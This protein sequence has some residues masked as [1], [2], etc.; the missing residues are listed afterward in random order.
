MIQSMTGYGKATAVLNHKHIDIE[1][2][3]LNSKNIDVN[4]RMPSEL[5]PFELGWRKSITQTLKRGKVDVQFNI[6]NSEQSKSISFNKPLVKSY[7]E[8]L[9][10]IIRVRD[11]MDNA[12]LLEIA[13][14]L[15]DAFQSEE[16]EMTKEDQTKLNNALK[17]ALQQVETFRHQEG[18][19]LME[20]FKN[21]LNEIEQHLKRIHEIDQNRVERVKT[22]LKSTLEELSVDYDKNR[23]EQELIYYIEKFD[24]SEEKTRLKSHIE[25]FENTLNLPE[26]NGKKLNFISQEMG[27]EINTIGSKANDAEIQNLVV[28]MKD[29]LEKI[30]EQM[31]NIL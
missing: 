18:Q 13:M 5:K 25:Y 20:V 9:Q 26:S 28:E 31:L 30:K 4:F 11:G 16:H 15:P 1:I 17:E 23:F 12:K 22:K 29:Q 8:N 10:D 7:I 21:N 19:N 2:R 27:R 24:I 14:S 6:E 3:T